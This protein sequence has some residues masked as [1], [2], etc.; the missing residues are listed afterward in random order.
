MIFGLV[1][2]PLIVKSVGL[3]RFGILTLIWAL[4]GYFSIF[5][6]GIGRA[7][8]YNIAKLLSSN[9]TDDIPPVIGSGLLLV[10]VVG[11]VGGLVLALSA[12]QMAYEWFNVSHQLKADTAS[13]IYITAIGI[14]LVTTMLGLKGIL[15]AYGE[16]GDLNI[17]KI[18]LG[19]GNFALPLLAVLF[20]GPKLEYM[21]F[22]LVLMRLVILVP[23]IYLVNKNATILSRRHLRS[24]G[25]Q[26]DLLLFGGWMTISNLVSPLMVTADR[27]LISNLLGANVV[28]YY[29]VPLDFLI[30][31]LVVPAALTTAAFPKFAS[32]FE[33]NII[34]FRKLYKISIAGV[35]IVMLPLCMAIALGSSWGLSLWLGDEFSSKASTLMS[36]I[37]IGILLNSVAQVPHAAIQAS[38]GVKTTA[39]L[40]IV[41]FFLYVPSLYFALIYHGLNGV[42]V[43]WVG[44]AAVDLVCLYYLAARKQNLARNKI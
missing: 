17:L 33:S 11:V 22:S 10:A 18:I 26:R 9:K 31:L 28:A 40:H 43:A 29:T 13:A 2:I 3:E 27:F 44:R 36:I 25:K 23:H 6:L 14:P 16:F 5:D 4:I 35:L 12:K 20:Y 8:T 34:G 39:L 15:E 7:L 24:K 1:A 41:E 37:S 21:A 32:L 19:I 38:G 30:R 42:A